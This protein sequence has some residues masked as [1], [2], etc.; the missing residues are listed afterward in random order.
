MS[1]GGTDM[2][3]TLLACGMKQEEQWWRGDWFQVQDV[4]QLY[5]GT[6]S[7]EFPLL[8]SVDIYCTLFRLSS[9]LSQTQGEFFSSPSILCLVRIRSQLLTKATL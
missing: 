4:S 6:G 2:A 8:Y 5:A 7:S 9:F 3:G 1:K